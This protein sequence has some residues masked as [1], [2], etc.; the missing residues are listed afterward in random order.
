M[1]NDTKEQYQHILYSQ[2]GEDAVLQWL[3]H[4]R[5]NGFYVDV[6]CH[7][8]YR[9]SNTAALYLNAAWHGLNIDVD[10]R[11][12]TAFNQ[13]RP[14]DI[15]ILMGVA[16]LEG[17]L[18]VTIFEEGA[19]NTFDEDSAAHPAWAHI[20]R[21]K[22]TVD[23]RPLKTILQEHLP[24]GQAIDLLSIDAEGVDFEVL[25]SNDWNLYRPEVVMV[26]AHDFDVSSPCGCATYDFLVAEG[27][28]L[29]SHV[30]VT[31]IYKRE[32]ERKD[33]LTDDQIVWLYK[34][35]LNREPESAET[36]RRI[37][38]ETRSFQEARRNLIN[39]Q[40]FTMSLPRTMQVFYIPERFPVAVR[41]SQKKMALA[42][43][44]K[45]EEAFIEGMLRSCAPLIDFAAIMDT[46]STDRT[47]DIASKTL[48]EL[49][50][51]HI[52]SQVPFETFS[53]AR[54]A[55]LELID[56]N[57]DWILMLDADE[58]ILTEDY[59][60]FSALLEDETVDG[61]QL[62]RFNFSDAARR[63]PPTLYP[64][65]Q[66]RLIRNKAENPIRFSGNVHEVPIN[67][68]KWGI[69]PENAADGSF[70]GGPHIHHLGY[71]E[72][73]QERWQKKHDFYTAL[74]VQES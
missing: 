54:N 57:I 45:D 40:E 22:R 56:G 61:W 1:T 42:T 67:V 36:I 12:I 48:S 17:R 20:P 52:V 32:L 16:G 37:K 41:K 34:C 6:G 18:D 47:I 55:V 68:D 74:R 58:E 7:H 64:D 62:P 39:T 30:A 66:R 11:A 73:T 10:P 26:E 14:N 8:P 27:Y 13:A 60:R 35:F 28:K 63:R 4:G 24:P 50:I 19:I 38:A 5:R 69:A 59:W 70:V 15:N 25:K 65:Y 23:V 44:V 71:I 2:F 43:I 9:F 72:I 31:S 53:Q 29:V 21:E 49:N 33:S 51:P 3:F 46:G